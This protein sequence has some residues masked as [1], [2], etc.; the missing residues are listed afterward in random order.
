MTSKAKGTICGIA[1]AMSYGCNPFALFLYAMGVSVNSVLSYRYGLATIVLGALMLMRRRNLRISRA[2]TALTAVLGILFAGSSLTLFLSFKFI[3]AGL[4]STMLFVYPVLV[5]A[6][7]TAFFGEHLRLSV[8]IAIILAVNGVIFLCDASVIGS[9]DIRGVLLV[10]LSSLLYAIY[11][12]I[13]KV[14]H[15]NLP[16]DLLTFYVLAW[17]T[18][19]IVT[20]AII[21]PSEPLQL[22]SSASAWGW[23]LFIALVPT[24]I[25]IILT[26][27]ALR[28]I[29]PTSTAI[30][31]ALEPMTAV[32]IGTVV[33]GEPFTPRLAAGIAVI[34][35]A[36]I[37]VVAPRPHLH[38]HRH[39][40]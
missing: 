39:A 38:P 17:G 20:F 5:A 34:L 32:M 21:S 4:A 1:A 7:M 30:L 14:S 35:F 37:L 31:G 33:F 24:V 26:N 19:G 22:L 3:D 40:R 6:I 9:G 10:L 2:Q 27:A 12:V 23:A 11:M 18:L 36:V 8:V 13:V 15:I 28:S 29:G 16:S 25:S